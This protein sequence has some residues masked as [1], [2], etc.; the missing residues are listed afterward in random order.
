M[1]LPDGMNRTY[2][3]II[4]GAGAAGAN[5]AARLTEDPRRS[6]LLLEAGPDFPDVEHLPEEIRYGYGH[7]AEM[8]GRAFGRET[9]YGWGYT[10]RATDQNP[11]MFVPRGRIIGGSSAVNA[12]VFLRGLPEDYDT[13]AHKCNSEW[14]YEKL[15]PYFERNEADPLHGTNGP[16]PVRRHTYDELNPDQRALYNAALAAGFPETDDH[17]APDSTGVGFIPLNNRDGVRWSTA[18]C[19]LDP[20]RER[21]NLT[22]RGD[23]L[24]RRVLFKGTRAIGVQV[25]AAE[26]VQEVHADEVV[27]CG[28]AIGSPTS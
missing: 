4:V 12:Q 3:T 8:W 5:I 22:I 27:L 25:E 24:V 14:S 20:A 26:G 6:V 16:I 11:A 13:W 23:C 28:G 1:L 21:A 9:K 17:N 10:A 2:D 7:G 19:Y 18:I 15:V